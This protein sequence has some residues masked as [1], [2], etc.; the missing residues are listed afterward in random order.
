[1]RPLRILVAE[2]DP[3]HQELL[4]RVL[5][6]HR[7]CVDVRVVESGAEFEKAVHDQRFDCVVID[8][9]LPDA[10]ADELLQAA[11][12]DLRGCPVIVASSNQT[13]QAAISSIRS[14]SVDF[15]PKAEALHGRTLWD[16]VRKATQETH[17]RKTEQ[18]K[19]ERRQKEL[20]RQADTDELTGLYN[21]RYLDRQLQANSYERDRRRDMS[22]I[23]MDIDHFKKT[24]DVHGHAAGDTV[25]KEISELLRKSLSG[26]DV[27]I[28]W[29]GE[30]FVILQGSTDLSEAW[31]WAEELRSRIA[32]LSFRTNGTEFNTTVSLGVVSFPTCKMGR[33][34]IGLAD[35]AMYLAKSQGR[36]RVCTWPMV[37]VDRALTKAMR[38]GASDPV[39]RRRKFLAC[40]EDVLG[41]TQIEHLTSHCEEVAKIAVKLAQ[42]M[43]LPRSE[44]GRIQVGGLLHDL[45]KSMIPEELLAQPEPLTKAQ[46]TVMGRHPD[47]S[48]DMSLRLGADQ[49]TA[50]CIRYHHLPWR[51]VYVGSSAAKVLCVADALAAMMAERAYR[52][53]RSAAEALAEVMRGAASQFDLTVASTAQSIEPFLASRAA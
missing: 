27:A 41:P 50:A 11:K 44:L 5:T 20:T 17:R 24:N 10:R 38:C 18:Q 40:C 35:R 26:G 8:Y 1:M 45:G 15:V 43:A 36:N 13:Q 39:R 22:C 16:R 25:L 4:Q 37:A 42:V 53:A 28:R 52:P 2:D 31:I 49:D 33:E 3:A 46:W 14:G 6:A 30:E 51:H 32:Q 47:Y 48:A 19:I 29:G 23:L 34:M 7:P 9:H 21:R 12:S